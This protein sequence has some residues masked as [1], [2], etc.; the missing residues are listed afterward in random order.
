[1]FVKI[2]L[3]ALPPRLFRTLTYPLKPA[4]MS[5]SP[6]QDGSEL[7]FVRPVGSQYQ[8]TICRSNRNMLF[9][10]MTRVKIMQHIQGK[11]HTIRA[12][13]ERVKIVALKQREEEEKAALNDTNQPA[14]PDNPNM[15]VDSTVTGPPPPPPP[16]SSDFLDTL[17]NPFEDHVNTYA[18]DPDFFTMHGSFDPQGYPTPSAEQPPFTRNRHSEKDPAWGPYPDRAHILTHSLFNA[19]HIHFSLAQ[20]QAVLDWAKAMGTLDVPTIYSLEKCQEALK[21]TIGDS[22]SQFSLINH[23]P[24]FFLQN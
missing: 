17:G 5:T 11:G 14:L 21:Q 18:F 8:C 6:A 16:L 22:S 2:R 19:P 4:D 3:Q 12:E 13:H 23:V 1:M 15:V 7:E 10:P 20:Q 9:E 24:Y